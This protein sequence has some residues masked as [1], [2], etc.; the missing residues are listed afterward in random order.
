MVFLKNKKENTDETS[1]RD[2]RKKI[3]KEFLSIIQPQ[4]GITFEDKYIKK[5][6]W[7]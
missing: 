2:V 5:R 7:V 3:D 4:G 1:S 6:R